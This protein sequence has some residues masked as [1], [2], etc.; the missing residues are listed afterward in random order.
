[1][2][3]GP[4]PEWVAAWA[5]RGEPVVVEYRS[6]CSADCDPS[7]HFHTPDFE[8]CERCGARIHTRLVDV[9]HPELGLVTVGSE[10]VKDLLGYKWSLSH[11]QAL[12]NQAAIESVL[13]WQGTVVTEYYKLKPKLL[14]NE[15]LHSNRSVMSAFTSEQRRYLRIVLPHGWNDRILRAG[16]DLDLPWLPEDRVIAVRGASLEAF[17][18]TVLER[19][20][21]PGLGQEPHGGQ[22]ATLEAATN[23]A[24]RWTKHTST[25]AVWQGPHRMVWH[26]LLIPRTAGRVEIETYPPGKWW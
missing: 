10:C 19:S 14:Q 12:E 13:G 21:G 4:K 20:L 2:A 16:A 3:R 23:E 6:L 24:I 15:H 11:E 1:M 18:W 22:S 17:N 5:E 7:E 8:T 9:A 25:A 26:G